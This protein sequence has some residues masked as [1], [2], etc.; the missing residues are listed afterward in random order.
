MILDKEAHYL[1]NNPIH[2]LDVLLVWRLK[3]VYKIYC[4]VFKMW[5]FLIFVF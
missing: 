4:N 1:F 2:I 3:A 5:L